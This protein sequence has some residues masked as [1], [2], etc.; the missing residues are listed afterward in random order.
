[1][2]ADQGNVAGADIRSMYDGVIGV[3]RCT[4]VDENIGDSMATSKMGNPAWKA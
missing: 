1:M 4:V 3:L 2:G